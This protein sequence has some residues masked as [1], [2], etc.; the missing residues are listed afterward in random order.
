[1][2]FGYYR[3]GLN[4]FR[5]ERMLNEM[6]RQVLDRLRLTGS[7]H[8]LIVDLGCGVGATVRYAASMFPQAQ[9]LGVTVVP[10]QVEK[11]N[12]WNRHLGLH[13]RVRLRLA[14]YTCTDLAPA[15]V[16]GAIA[17]ESECHAEGP[18]KEPFIREAARILK[19]GARLVRG[20]F[21]RTEGHSD[22]FRPHVT[23]LCLSFWSRTCQIEGF[24]V[25]S[26]HV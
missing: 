26:Q 17:I 20:G 7:P 23:V 9:I 11:G 22:P 6:N 12:A 19:R 8:D 2:H 4:P 5:R 21:R 24:R 10:W 25:P 3:F 15:S 1:M 18:T 14:D 16:D 13:E